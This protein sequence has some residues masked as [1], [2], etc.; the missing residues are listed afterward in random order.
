MNVNEKKKHSAVITAH[1][2]DGYTK[3][4]LHFSSRIFG[5][6]SLGKRKV[7]AKLLWMQCI[8]FP[9]FLSLRSVSVWLC[10]VVFYISFIF[11]S[12]DAWLSV[13]ALLLLLLLL[14]MSLE[15]QIVSS[16]IIA[17]SCFNVAIAHKSNTAQSC[18]F[19]S[20]YF[21]LDSFF[22]CGGRWK[23]KI[24]IIY[25]HLLL[26]NFNCETEKCSSMSHW[27]HSRKFILGIKCI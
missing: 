6:D 7:Q 24:T 12:L 3:H 14:L 2:V 13:S 26:I 25:R 4:W 23:A 20:N 21:S 1:D 5:L 10:F 19:Y 8:L 15:K 27:M 22:A 18:K 16:T 11:M 9:D 17:I